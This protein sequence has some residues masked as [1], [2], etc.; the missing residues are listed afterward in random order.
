MR[1]DALSHRVGK[2][3]SSVAK[4]ALEEAFYFDYN[5]RD[6]VATSSSCLM[7]TTKKVLSPEKVHALCQC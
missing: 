1:F 4:N 5:F 6:S 3:I 7:F 2:Y